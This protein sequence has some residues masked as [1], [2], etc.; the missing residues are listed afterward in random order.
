MKAKNMIA[1][2]VIAGMMVSGAGY[3]Y[4]TDALTVDNTVATGNL[5]V[6]FTKAFGLPHQINKDNAGENYMTGSI[7]QT[8]DTLTVTMEDMYPGAMSLYA[9]KAENFGSIPAVLD[10]VNVTFSEQAGALGNDVKAAGGFIQMSSKHRIKDGGYFTGTL[11]SLEDDLNAMLENVQMEPGDYILFDIPEEHKDEVAA[12]IP[13]YN[14][15]EENCIIFYL[16]D[17]SGN[18]TENLR[19]QFDIDFNWKQH[20]A[21]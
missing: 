15:S 1:S 18:E 9:A 8:A 12:A 21:Q 13:A 4:W 11:D 16:D 6:Q 5:D 20:N 19:T 3:A 2:A 17:Q 10:H 14:P 7:T